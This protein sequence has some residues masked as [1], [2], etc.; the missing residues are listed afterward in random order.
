MTKRCRAATLALVVILT[1]SLVPTLAPA[2]AQDLDDFERARILRVLALLHR[3]P[4]A[5]NVA[6]PAAKVLGLAAND[7]AITGTVHGLDPE[8]YESAAVMAWPADSLYAEDGQ[9]VDIPYTTARAMV[10]PDGTYRLEGLAPGPYSVS[11]M[12]KGYETRYYEGVV[13]VV[14]GETVEGIDLNLEREHTGEGSI[15]GV[16]T[17][18]ADGHPIAGAIVHAFATHSPYMYGVAETGEDGRYLIEGLRSGRY[19]VE[20][21]S[22]DHLP[23]FYGGVMEYEQAV[24]VPVAE[25]ERTDGID[26]RLVVGGAIAGVV[27]NADGEPVAGAYVTATTPITSDN[28][29]WID[30]EP[31]GRLSPVAENGWGV[32]DE[33]GAYRLGGLPT[34]EYWVQA[35]ASTRWQYVSIWY[36]GAY[37][38]EEA[39]PIAVITGQEIS[40]ID[41]ALQLPAL[42]SS[43]AGRVTGPDGSPVTKA[44][45]TV[46]EAVD[47]TR[48][49]SVF[50]DGQ[51][52][53]ERPM[54][55]EGSDL[56]DSGRV[57]EL[58]PEEYTMMRSSVWA[59]AATDEDGRYAIDELPAGT[60]IVSAASESGWEYVERWYVDADSP[61]DA[62]EVVIGK[63]ERVSGIDI[64]L[65]VRVA[66]ASISGT[67]RDQEGNILK[68]AFI[69]VGPTEGSV[70]TTS[71]DERRLW[72][73][74]QTDSTGA[75]RVD[76][77]PAGTYTVHASINMDNRYG[78][79]W[80]DGADSP[81]T[82]T[83][84]IVTEGESRTGV[85]MQLLVRPLYGDI[86]GTVT[87]A[88]GDSPVSG[89]YV[90]LSPLDRDVIRGA[91][92]RYWA[93]STVTD[94][95]GAFRMD[96]IPEGVYSL[97]VYAN[98]AVADY[99]HPDTDALSTPFRVLG[100]ETTL[101]DVALTVRHDGEG[102]I[103]GTVTTAYPYPDSPPRREEPV[104]GD[105]TNSTDDRPD[106][107]SLLW[108]PVGPPQIAVVVAVPVASP[109]AGPQYTAVTGPDGT[110]ALRG[111]ASG[112]YVI[113]CFAPG[114]IGTYYDGAYSPD[115]AQPVHVEG[116]QQVPFIDFELAGAYWCYGVDED[117][118]RDAD[119]APTSAEASGGPALYGNVADDS[120]QPVEDATVYLL[121]ADE[122]P[123][124]FTQ[125]GSDGSFELS[126]V[127]PGEYRLYAGRLG[128]T[129]SY[130]GNEHDFAAAAPLGVT[131]GQTEVNLVLSIGAVTAVEEDTET[132]GAVPLVMALYPNYPNPFNPQTRIAFAVP[133]AG[134]ATLRIHNAL[135]QQVVALFDEAVEAGRAYEVVF[136]ARGL[137]AG[138]Y[139]CTLDL[140]GR[141]LVRPMTL[142]K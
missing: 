97:T 115:K 105:S 55:S 29:D 116:D 23:G 32:T 141:R 73:Y 79:G 9:P 133:T 123:V 111:L 50:S 118:I 49:D 134:R 90:E 104:L 6:G 48:V 66:T 83:P 51:V 45:V 47:W 58:M 135:G 138:I 125:T 72:A 98:G 16:V 11:A 102:T 140:R 25:P 78:H 38:L 114:H 126:G 94:E 88:S 30:D 128:Y 130:N 54:S 15:A 59:Y 56:S 24:P 65:P 117:T 1:S 40:G 108:E 20:V 89:A 109:D 19:V 84:L 63:G 41:M 71:R 7:G 110:Y 13:D 18:G 62:T 61:R 112:D 43:V 107:E 42:D 87:D 99:V 5:S 26:F 60:Y 85:D 64:V 68:W 28:L 96:W 4:E 120:G 132:E 106:D 119:M 113:M 12:A 121:D 136:N 77:L 22:Q 44:F 137:G 80:Y 27:R 57:V 10:Q 8:D 127:V 86:V 37:T 69:E 101:C 124:A 53:P 34:G 93:T 17:N 129:G 2:A 36:D 35:Q 52:S 131:G 142:V 70:I 122:Q 139:Y 21:L 39:T 92:L 81:E 46:R 95:S 67:V 91:P 82:A 76:R 33:N 103:T 75:Y 74:G 3:G 14:D 100:G 31:D